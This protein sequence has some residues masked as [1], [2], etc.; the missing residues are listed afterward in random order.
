MP[1]ASRYVSPPQYAERLGVKPDKVLAWINTGE[2]RAVNTATF[3][4]GRPRWRIPPDAII[5]IEN[6]RAAKPPVRVRRRPR[7]KPPDV[8]EYF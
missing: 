3:R 7:E 8:V 6:S 2:L 5:A 1:D 4:G